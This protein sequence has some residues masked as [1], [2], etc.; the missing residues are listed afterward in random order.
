MRL[1]LLLTALSIWSNAAFATTINL[2][3]VTIDASDHLVCTLWNVS[4]S[5]VRVSRIE[6]NIGDAGFHAI[7]DQVLLPDGMSSNRVGGEFGPSFCR[8]E[9]KA[10][11]AS[12]RATLCIRGGDDGGN[13]SC[14]VVLQGP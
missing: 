4:S 11:A 9:F 14:K 7:T 2:G 6:A 3:P 5:R 8:F 10:H 13:V 12:V 1:I